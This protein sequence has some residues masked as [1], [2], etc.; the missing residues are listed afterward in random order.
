[1]TSTRGRERWRTTVVWA[2]ALL[3]G[4][5]VPL[6]PRLNPDFGRLG[7]DKALH[8]LG[9]MGFAAGLS[10]ALQPRRSG[11]RAGMIALGVSTLFGL[12]TELLQERI[13]GR[14]FEVWDLIAGGFGSILGIVASDRSAFR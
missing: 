12:S 8:A 10:S 7:P 9:H 3:L 1:M 4:S 14:E 13:P 5:A 2:T 6:P 11:I